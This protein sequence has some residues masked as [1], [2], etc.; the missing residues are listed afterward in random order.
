MKQKRENSDFHLLGWTAKYFISFEAC[1][2]KMMTWS[3]KS[4]TPRRLRLE[5]IWL[6]VQSLVSSNMSQYFPSTPLRLTF[7]TREAQHFSHFTAG[8]TQK[9]SYNETD[10]LGY[11]EV[12]VRL[13]LGA[14]QVCTKYLSLVRTIC[15]G[16]SHKLLLSLPLSQPTRLISLYLKPP[17][18]LL[19]RTR[20]D[21]IPCR[22]LHVGPS[23]PYPTTCSSL[24]ST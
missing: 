8:K 21:T 10:S 22:R 23:L 2:R 14:Y 20:K 18:K 7:S 19:E 16:G 24:H 5:V 15:I 3:G 1:K 4:G 17:R 12:S 11:G 6:L 13:L 9:P